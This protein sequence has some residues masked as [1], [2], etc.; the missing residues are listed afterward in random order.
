MIKKVMLILLCA[1]PFQMSAQFNNMYLDQPEYSGR[2]IGITENLN[3]GEYF[4]P[5]SYELDADTTDVGFLK[6]S[7]DG[8]LNELKHLLQIVDYNFFAWRRNFFPTSDGGH[9]LS[10]SYNGPIIYKLDSN[11]DTLWVEREIS[12][13]PYFC[14]GGGELSNGDLVLGY[15]GQGIPWNI[16]EMR[17][18][19]SEGELLQFFDVDIDYDYSYPT[20]FITEDSL[21]Y[22]SFS[23]LLNNNYRRNYIVCYNAITGQEIWE[24][25]Q[26]ENGEALGFTEGYMCKSSQGILHLVH[27]EMTELAWPNT[28]N[29]AYDGF[30]KTQKI[31]SLTGEFLEKHT[32]SD[33]E[34]ETRIIDAVTTSDGG[35]AILIFGAPFPYYQ[36][37][38]V[39]GSMEVEW[40]QMYAPP[41]PIKPFE[42]FSQLNEIKITSDDCIIAVGVAS[43]TNPAEQWSFEHPWLLKV[44]A[45]GNEIITDC[46]LSGVGEL[47]GR[48]KISIYPNPARDRVFLKAENA[49]QHAMI[50]DMN[51]KMVHDEIFSGA[52]EQTL[53]ID[54]LP[55]SLYLVTAI[56][57]KGVRSSTRVVVEK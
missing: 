27:L 35:L 47:S 10:G 4:V 53:F 12:A 15:S 54:H 56:D 1:Y 24:S 14:W 57:N 3:T 43:A 37:I 42:F 9:V 48:N 51:G 16:L 32:F 38:K 18:Y 13:S 25:H 7:M 30:V 50:F 28:F 40:R 19:S 52:Q 2:A 22:I 17:R 26:I 49:I 31:N 55:Q 41:V 33:L 44:D 6:V 23:R 21:L 29:V 34:G 39:D 5:I 36:I 11:L 46:S 8:S 20:T 45:C